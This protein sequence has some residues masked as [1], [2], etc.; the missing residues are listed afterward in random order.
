MASQNKQ[1]F[2]GSARFTDVRDDIRT[3]IGIA[4]WFNEFKPVSRVLRNVLLRLCYGVS[5][6][7]NYA[8]QLPVSLRC[9]SVVN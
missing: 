1:Y 7:W 8:A 5:I 3:K 6:C 4:T 9:L 2:D